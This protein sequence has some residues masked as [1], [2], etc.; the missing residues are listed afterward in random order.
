[1]QEVK[2][3]PPLWAHQLAAIERYKVNPSLFNASDCGV[4]K[5]RTIIEVMKHL[6]LPTLIL[7]PKSIL[8][9]SWGFDL[10]RF[11][12]ELKYSIATALNRRAAFESDAPIKI[13]NIDALT[14]LMR[15]ENTDL[16]KQFEGGFLVIDEVSSCKNP[17][18]KRTKAAFAIRKIFAHCTTMT[19]TP[20][21]NGLIDIWAPIFLVDQGASLGASF[22][23]F[24]AHTH[25]QVTKG[26]F[27]TWSEKPGC[28]DAVGAI[29]APITIRAAR[30][31]CLDLPEHQIIS[32]EVILSAAHLKQYQDLRRLAVLELKTGTI[33]AVNAA[34]LCGKLLQCASGNV[35]GE[36]GESHL[37]STDR[38]NMVLDIVEEQKQS[39]VFYT[40]KFQ[41]EQ[42]LIG[43]KARGISYG[44]LDGSIGTFERANAVSEFQAGKLKTL[45]C[46]IS[47]A[48]HGLTLTAA[49]TSI[50]V[51]P[52]HNAESFEQSRHR[53]YRGGQTQK[54]QT[55]LI[56]APGTI[57]GEVYRALND[58]VFKMDNLLEM[59]E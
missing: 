56:Q 18:A 40:W 9:A 8:H 23:R 44:L 20:A 54:T 43:A 55:I 36:N 47:A 57:E 19:G 21:S 15:P 49:T 6:Q 48:S 52:T 30:D 14:W 29:I 50:Y 7:A 34:V 37:L 42:L 28:I 46:Q 51:S 26:A 16:R 53:I 5:S 12:P 2:A 3:P 27:S 11:A 32:R 31:E 4:G 35:Y 41:K 45:I 1:M 39:V 38:Y 59:L 58:K 10:K 22:Y 13:T 17:A 33:T 25:N 24:R